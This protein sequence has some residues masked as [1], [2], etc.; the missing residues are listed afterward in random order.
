[1]RN[2]LLDLS[3][4]EDGSCDESIGPSVVQKKKMLVKRLAWLGLFAKERETNLSAGS[5]T[6]IGRKGQRLP[7]Q[8]AEQTNKDKP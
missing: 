8:T 7:E 5:V 4:S 6:S 2:A 3:D 1:M